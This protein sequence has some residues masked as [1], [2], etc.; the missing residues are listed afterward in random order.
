MLDAH[1][2]PLGADSYG[3]GCRHVEF[4]FLRHLCSAFV[5]M[6]T[7]NPTVEEM[8]MD[9]AQL[10]MG[11]ARRLHDVIAEVDE[12]ERVASLA[13][14]YHQVS[15][16]VRQSLVLRSRFEAGIAPVQRAAPLARQPASAA[17]ATP[18]PERIGWNEH[19]RLEADDS[20]LEALDRI[21][22]AAEDEP[23]DIAEAERVITAGLAR[24]RSETA[25][26]TMPPR[27]VRAATRT[28]LLGA[29]AARRVMDSS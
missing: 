17:P 10:G 27:A 8:L 5:L 20:L 9:L 13:I 25:R 29:T 19:E 22:D 28:A 15:R 16:G 7:A 26:L 6:T 21:S 2:H 23:L 4:D 3:S 12:P 1:G 11:V 18:R 24:I 14:A